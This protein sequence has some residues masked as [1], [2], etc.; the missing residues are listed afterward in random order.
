V[1]AAGMLGVYVAD[2]PLTRVLPCE[3]LAGLPGE[4][5]SPT[6]GVMR[7]SRT[8]AHLLTLG[9]LCRSVHEVALGAIRRLAQFL[10][11]AIVVAAV[12]LA[13]GCSHSAGAA[14]GSGGQ[15]ATP[16]AGAQAR[17]S[18]PGISV[19]IP[20]GWQNL[21]LPASQHAVAAV[22][23]LNPPC[24]NTM[25][26]GPAACQDAVT[27]TN[28][29]GGSAAQA[30]EQAARIRFNAMHHVIRAVA[31][32]GHRAMTLGG[33]PAYMTEWHVTWVR[34]PS[35]LEERIVVRTGV[36]NANSNLES[37]FIRFADTSDSRPRASIKEIVSSIRCK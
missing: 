8:G 12:C 20:R 1:I 31:V 5:M 15:A 18:F 21:R 25:F 13:A 36:A 32:L 37:V 24:P 17:L 28:V 9:V 27:I 26:G 35:T 34:Q 10:G 14:P 3:L 6:A 29:R 16:T 23:R 11:A 33:C 30:L 2:L 19:A 4:P 7:M 22:P